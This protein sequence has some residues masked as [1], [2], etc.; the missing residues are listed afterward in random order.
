[1][2]AEWARH[3]M[4]LCVQYAAV[5]LDQRVLSVSALVSQARSS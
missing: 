5:R 2:L 1:M 4:V 3:E